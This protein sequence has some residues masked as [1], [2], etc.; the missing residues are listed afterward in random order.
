[1]DDSNGVAVD[2]VDE[3]A[4]FVVRPLEFFVFFVV[5]ADVFECGDARAGSDGCAC[6]ARHVGIVAKDKLHPCGRL[7]R[8]KDQP[9]YAKADQINKQSDENKYRRF[10]GQR[11]RDGIEEFGA[12]A[13]AVIVARF[14][15]A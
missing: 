12:G 8:R 11:A 15:N 14:R 3:F 9:K 2:F 13:H 10:A 1:M 6:G 4:H 5:L 7:Q